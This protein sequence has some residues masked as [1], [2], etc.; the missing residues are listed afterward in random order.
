[1]S[2]PPVKGEKLVLRFLDVSRAHPHCPLRR[3]V[4][5]RLPKDC[6]VP[7]GYVVLLLKALYGLRDA[8]QSFELLAAKLMIELEF[9]QGLFSP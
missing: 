6:G 5:A 2:L 8:N 1:M 3:K 7:A 9:T 4:Y